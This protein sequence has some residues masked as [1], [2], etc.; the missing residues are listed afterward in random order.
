MALLSTLGFGI[1]GTAA[2]A[3]KAAEDDQPAAPAVAPPAA[4]PAHGGK[5][6]RVLIISEDGMRPDMISG[7]HMEWHEH[8]YHGG[9]S[10]FHARTIRTAST[11][12]SHASMLSGVD[13]NRHGLSW[14]NWRPSKGFIHVPTIFKE[15]GEH[16]L[17]TAA[18][19]GKFKLRHILPAGTVGVFER[20]GYYCKKVSEEAAR[21]LEKE[22]PD[23][24]FVHFSDPDEAGHSAG[25]LSEKYLKAGQSADKCLGTL[26]QALERAGTLDE[27]LIIVSADHGGHNHTHSGALACDREIPWIAYGPNVRQGYTLHEPISTMDTAA[28]ALVALGLPVPTQFIGKPVKEMYLSQP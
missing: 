22:K 25:W 4:A 8:L 12:P 28:T 14:N 3:A 9:S 13:V 11:L 19:V 18:F 17:K 1:A 15:A 7:Q 10:S 2:E 20:P 5:V 27:T 24:A 23:L 16:G 26:L 6:K 21:Y